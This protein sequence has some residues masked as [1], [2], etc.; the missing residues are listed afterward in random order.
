MTVAVLLVVV[1]VLSAWWIQQGQHVSN[2]EVYDIQG[3]YFVDGGISP[4]SPL[5]DSCM[6]PQFG[7]EGVQMLVKDE[8]GKVLGSAPI[9]PGEDTPRGG[10]EYRFLLE[11][12]PRAES[13]RFSLST[14]REDQTRGVYSFEEMQEMGWKVEFSFFMR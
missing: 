2:T 14:G 12:I 9:G 8:G 13:Y 11:D 5:D 3:S 10:C 1:L 6:Y 4:T 7:Q